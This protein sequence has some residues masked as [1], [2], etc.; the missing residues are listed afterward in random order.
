MK[1][2]VSIAPLAVI[3]FASAPLHVGSVQS[4]TKSHA[5]PPAAATPPPVHFEDIARQ[6][7]LTATDVYGN[8]THKEYIIETTG[9]GAII[10]DY[11]NDGWPDIF[12]P[13]G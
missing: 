8:D 3:L 13:N 9:N 7:G 2:W 12:L 10:F 1:T 6:A 11:D 4:Q 5:T